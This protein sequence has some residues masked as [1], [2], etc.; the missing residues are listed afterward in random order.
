MEPAYSCPI[1]GDWSIKNVTPLRSTS[2]LVITSAA[3]KRH[4]QYLQRTTQHNYDTRQ[5]PEGNRRVPGEQS[6]S[7]NLRYRLLRPR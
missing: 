2:A 4:R 5:E 7:D 6:A 3:A 1:L